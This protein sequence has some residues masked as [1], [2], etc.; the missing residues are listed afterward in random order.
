MSSPFI[1]L[2]NLKRR[3]AALILGAG[4]IVAGACYDLDVTAVQPQ[5][6][7]TG[8]PGCILQ[9][10]QG[11]AQHGLAAEVLHPVELLQRAYARDP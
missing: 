1:G 2:A 10:R 11:V 4:A 5:L 3:S 9:L 8:N 6:I 7:V